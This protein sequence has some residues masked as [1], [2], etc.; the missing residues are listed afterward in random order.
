M[1]LQIR[2]TLWR[3]DPEAAEAPLVFDSPHSG[4]VY[5]EDFGF[6]CPLEILRQAEDAHVDALF[7]AAPAFGATLIG[8]LFPRSYLDANRAVDD[9]DPELLDAPPP[10]PLR[11][12][13]KTAAGIGLIRRLAKPGI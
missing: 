9:L 13:E 2:D 6:A 7:A 1:S 3:R 11:P 5:P 12:S 4:D 8:A 10:W